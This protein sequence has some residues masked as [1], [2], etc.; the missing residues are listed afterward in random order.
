MSKYP[1]FAIVVSFFGLWL[2]SFFSSENQ[3]FTGFVFILT[4]G[5]L[6]GANDLLIIKNL[7]TENTAIS[8]S[9]MLFY[10]LLMVFVGGILF[11]IIPAAILIFFI[12]IS[13]FHFGEQQLTYLPKNT[14]KNMLQ[15]LQI[16]YGL[17]ILFLLFEFHNQEVQIIVNEI[18]TYLLA[19]NTITYCLY[20]I[21]VLFG[22]SFIWMYN[23]QDIYKTKLLQE[24]FY[25]L[26][27]AIIF[28]VS[29]LIWGFAIYFIVWHSIPSII[30]QVKFLYGSFS[31]INFIS[32]FK[33]AVLYW[34]ISLLGLAIFYFGFK[35]LQLFNS[36]FFSFLAAITFPHVLVI[37]KM[38]NQKS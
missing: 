1:S 29:S 23:K 3:V 20:T 24:L 12:L 17:L 9:K 33:S 30:D 22:I 4:F 8:F 36:M 13:G 34:I 14:N 5:I 25:L 27:F 26:V 10:Y 15:G 28:K 2:T 35:D 11:Y 31:K 37:L 18:T 6:H 32:Y 38:F 16:L 19:P 7:L 21:I